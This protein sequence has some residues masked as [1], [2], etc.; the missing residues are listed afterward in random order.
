MLTLFFVSNPVSFNSWNYQKHKGSG[1]SDQS[2]F[3]L[4]KKVQKYSFIRYILSD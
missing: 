1:T 3:R 4:Q 2:L